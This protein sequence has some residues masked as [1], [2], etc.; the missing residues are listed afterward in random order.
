M[1]FKRSRE[2]SP[3]DTLT[4]PKK[5][6]NLQL[7]PT[8][9]TSNIKP[10]VSG[11]LVA[12]QGSL[13]SIPPLNPS[14]PCPP[15]KREDSV[16]RVF[17]VQP[18]A[19]LLFGPGTNIKAEPIVKVEELE[20]ESDAASDHAARPQSIPSPRDESPAPKEEEEELPPLPVWTSLWDIWAVA[21]RQGVEPVLPS[22]G[23]YCRVAGRVWNPD[24]NDFEMTKCQW[25][26]ELKYAKLERNGNQGRPYYT[27]NDHNSWKFHIF[28][29]KVGITSDGENKRCKCDRPSRKGYCG[30]EARN[31]GKWWWDC[32]ERQCTYKI[33]ENSADYETYWREGGE[34]EWMRPWLRRQIRKNKLPGE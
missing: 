30:R 21:E 1:S 23:P 18:V 13:P 32:V 20:D 8:P 29:D 33:W 2:A 19:R 9:P 26:T 22:H 27:C 14:T 6:R 24:T 10:G 25:R 28:A 17:E 3:D 31:P 7:P 5:H 4:T 15:V 34:I 11:S 16:P 12:E